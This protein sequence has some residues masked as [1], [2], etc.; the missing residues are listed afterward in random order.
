M[1]AD[2]YCNEVLFTINEKPAQL[3]AIGFENNS[4]GFELRN[5]YFKGCNSPKD[6]SYIHH[7]RAEKVTVFEGFLTF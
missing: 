3:R 4:G 1:I 2:K 5:A 7:P 6:A